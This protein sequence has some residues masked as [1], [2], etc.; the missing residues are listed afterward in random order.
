[1]GFSSKQKDEKAESLIFNFWNEIYRTDSGFILWC[2]I[3]HFSH[4][5]FPEK[6]EATE[7]IQQFFLYRKATFYVYVTAKI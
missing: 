6:F 5:V 1:M 2:P 3:N 7:A 4:F